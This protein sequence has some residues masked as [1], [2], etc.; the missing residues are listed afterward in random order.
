MGFFR[1][2][3]G[4]ERRSGSLGDLER[5]F[6]LANTTASGLSV[7]PDGALQSPTCLACVRVL[8]ESISQ[9]PVHVF[10]RGPN[11]EKD[12]AG[13][14]PVEKLISGCPIDWMTSVEFRQSMMTS[15]LLHGAAYAWVGRAGGRV[16]EIVPIA[17]GVITRETDRLTGEPRFFATTT[18]GGRREVDRRDLL[19]I[20]LPGADPNRDLSLVHLLRESIALDIAMA[21]YAAKLFAKGCRPSGAL[22][23]SG[24]LT[25]EA[26]KRL[27]TSVQAAHSGAE[28]GKLIVLEEGLSFEQMQFSSVD[29]Q[30]LET[31]RRLTSEICRGF[32]VPVHLAQD[33]ERAT[34]SNSEHMS[35]SFLTL[36]MMPWIKIW[37]QAMMRDLLDEG[38]REDFY[39]EF[40][41]ADLAR[42]DLSARFNAYTA[43]AN[44]GIL[45]VNEIRAL[46][47][48][49]PLPGGDV[50]R[51]PL[52]M[53]NAAGQGGKA[54]G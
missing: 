24:R 12:R 2:L 41:T 28:A 37:E 9:I 30:Y 40:V 7:S 15:A 48:R 52:N 29:A 38:E 54:D 22:K 43:A 19:V 13:D 23:A 16:V 18:D 42:A 3:V 25:P 46:E 50:L 14:H 1:R 39:I 44:A 47:S 51:Q 17:P 21:G 11:G 34:W 32:R 49:P 35:Q 36:T 33:W 53:T 10:R 45:T 5:L 20:R 6:A 26:I 31:W 4:L 8:S 27:Q